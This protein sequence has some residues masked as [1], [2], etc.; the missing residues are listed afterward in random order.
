MAQFS[1]V[2][3]EIH[4]QQSPYSPIVTTTLSESRDILDQLERLLEDKILIEANGSPR[5]RRRAWAR[6]R[7]K[8]HNIQN[9]LAE[10]RANLTIALVANSSSVSGPSA[11]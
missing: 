7:N 6:Y 8:V 9:S 1:S 11:W 2:V 5:V 4:E 3:Q 10:Y